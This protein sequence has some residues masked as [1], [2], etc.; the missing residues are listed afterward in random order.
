VSADW[1]HTGFYPAA[2]WGISFGS[3]SRRQPAGDLAGAAAAVV[4]RRHGEARSHPDVASG[5]DAERT[6]VFSFTDTA[7]SAKTKLRITST[8]G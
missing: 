2:R 7:G 5:E 4:D 8:R 3:D 6:V 1:I